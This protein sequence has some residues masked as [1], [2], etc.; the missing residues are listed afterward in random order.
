M[1]SAPGPPSWAGPSAPGAGKGVY[2]MPGGSPRVPSAPG[3]VLC[4]GHPRGMSHIEGVPFHMGPRLR[5]AGKRVYLMPGGSPAVPSAPA[6]PGG[7]GR[8]WRIGSTA[9]LHLGWIDREILGCRVIGLDVHI[10][11]RRLGHGTDRLLP[12]DEL[13]GTGRGILDLEVALGV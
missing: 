2:P 7:M 6:T 5:G 12:D 9:R 10:I 11:A 8:A 4:P 3:H 1:R 13:L